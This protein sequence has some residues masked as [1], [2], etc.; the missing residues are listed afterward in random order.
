[1]DNNLETIGNLLIRLF[2]RGFRLEEYYYVAFGK[3]GERPLNLLKNV[4]SGDPNPSP[5]EIRKA[6]PPKFTSAFAKQK[7]HIRQD[8]VKCKFNKTDLRRMGDYLIPPLSPVDLFAITSTLL[9]DSGA[10]HHFE[11]DFGR[12][13]SLSYP[14]KIGVI[15][16]SDI[17]NWETIGKAW[18]EYDGSLELDKT[19]FC[20]N[21]KRNPTVTSITNY[22]IEILKCWNVSVYDIVREDKPQP[23]WWQP[24]FA[25]MAISDYASKDVGFRFSDSK[26]D[27]NSSPWSRLA[28]IF[29]QEFART[30]GE[31]VGGRGY[32][33]DDSDRGY[34]YIESLSLANR[35]IVNVL[36]KSRTAQV[37][38]TLR[39]ATHNL[40]KLPGRGS[41]RVGWT[42][43]KA[44][45][46][47]V[48]NTV[49]NILLIP[50]P[51]E[52]H[53]FNFRPTSVDHPHSRKPGLFSPNVEPDETE[54]REFV[55]FVSQL[56]VKARQRLGAIHGLVLPEL[57][58]SKKTAL[59]I[60]ERIETD[61]NS[62]ELVCLGVRERM[63]P[64]K[65]PSPTNGAYMAFFDAGKK[66]QD[67]FYEKHHRWKLTGDQID[68]YDLSP[69]LDPSRVWWEDIRITN[70]CMP[71]LV[72][73]NRWTVTSL[74][75]EDLA[76]NDPARGIVEAIGP[77]L[78]ISLLLDGP[79]IESRWPAR[80]A[81]VLA[82]DP[83]SAVLSISSRGLIERSNRKSKEEKFEPSRAFALWRD[84]RGKTVPIELED[85]HHAVAISVTEYPCNDQT[86]Y[87]RSD[88]GSGLALRLTGVRQIK[89]D[90]QTGFPP[91]G[92]TKKLP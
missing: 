45:A 61:H 18:Y 73:R 34:R 25:L 23:D 32:G 42:L 65:P 6:L 66:K 92:S 13:R 87:G 88:S 16:E 59:K 14:T 83:G 8:L 76:R 26:R 54:D 62:V 19:P 74:I 40:A 28:G 56:L 2:P 47:T 41:I 57:S 3:D 7:D 82:E 1:M 75:C 79:Q 31:V 69:S 48:E 29:L 67:F 78:V 20:V 43:L 90:V 4:L 35:D 55:E 72:M 52:I 84:D 85:G 44:E 37:G 24:A 81:T 58:V 70:R 39:G 36:P 71:I 33:E 17:S 5:D 22:W 46:D 11:A 10:Y 77:N 21:C 30:T 64:G 60:T 63:I 68:M 89:H 38:Y 9:A 12:D 27:G 50:Y 86:F 49:F 15:N 53:S 80:Y 91:W 51:Y